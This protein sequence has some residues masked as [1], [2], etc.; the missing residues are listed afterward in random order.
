MIFH[1]ARFSQKQLR[2]LRSTD[3]KGA[4]L[5]GS[6][7]A[8]MIL[9]LVNCRVFGP[10]AEA[11]DGLRYACARQMTIRLRLKIF[12]R[13]LMGFEFHGSIDFGEFN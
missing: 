9:N 4:F 13:N 11:T 5:K 6:F 1:S 12:L 2:N 3:K 10:H 8:E 7:K